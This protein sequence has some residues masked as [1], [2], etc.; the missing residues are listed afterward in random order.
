MLAEGIH[1]ELICDG[2][3]IVPDMVKLAC[4]VRGYD[5][6]ELITDSMRA[7]GMPEGKSELGGQVVI[8]KDGMA[9]SQEVSLHTF[10]HLKM[11]WNLQELLLKKRL[12]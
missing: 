8:V 4:K 6:I 10:R 2:K 7:K 5:G 11:L 3:H 9:K 1:A 12:R